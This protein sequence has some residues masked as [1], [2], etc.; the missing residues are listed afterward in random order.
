[1]L[2]LR[3]PPLQYLVEVLLVK[4]PLQ[5]LLVVLLVKPLLVV[6]LGKTEP[7]ISTSSFTRETTLKP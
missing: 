1:M 7:S 5:Y 6:L 4:P 3:K 2:L